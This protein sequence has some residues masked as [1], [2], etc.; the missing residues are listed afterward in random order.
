LLIVSYNILQGTAQRLALPARAGFGGENHQTPNPLF[1]AAS[2]KVWTTARTC[3]VH[4]VL[5]AFC[6]YYRAY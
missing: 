5:A 4:A 3:P 6:I 2:S 1:G